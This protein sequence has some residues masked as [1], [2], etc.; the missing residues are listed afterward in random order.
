MGITNELGEELL[1]RIREII[2]ECGCLP[3]P[4]RAALVTAFSIMVMLD[5]SGESLGRQYRV[6][7]E[8]GEPVLF[9][10]HDLQID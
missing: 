1:D 4:E 8:D 2:K 10:H 9:F 3:T 5:G 6:Y 7:T